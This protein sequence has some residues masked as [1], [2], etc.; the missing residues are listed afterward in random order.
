MSPSWLRFPAFSL[1]SFAPRDQVLVGLSPERLSA[2]HLG[3][4][5]RRRLLDKYEVNLTSDPAGGMGSTAGGVHWEPPVGALQAL[6]SRPAWNRADVTVLLSNHYVH[7]AVM[8]LQ[9][10]LRESERDALARVLFRKSYGD[11]CSTWEFRVSPADAAAPTTLASGVS[12]PL[13]NSIAGACTDGARLRSVQPS[14][15]PMFNRLRRTVGKGSGTLAVVEFGR[16]TLAHLEAGQWQSVVS[17][18][19]SGGLL[20]PLLDEENQLHERAPGGLLWLCDLTGA[21]RIPPNSPWRVQQ[22]AP[23]ILDAG[24][25]GVPELAAWGVM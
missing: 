2:L 19:D 13:L 5:P 25:P 4:G 14:L 18:A 6:L 9:K 11:L 15:M 8:P 22:A 7:Y 17:R 20:F 24:T 21:V 23:D 3:R 16:V 10:G 12:Q 1:S